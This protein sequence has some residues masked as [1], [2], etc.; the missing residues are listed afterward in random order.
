MRSGATRDE[1]K[2]GKASARRLNLNATWA[3]Y[4]DPGMYFKPTDQ[5]GMPRRQGEVLPSAFLR[6]VTCILSLC[7]LDAL[8]LVSAKG[9][10]SVQNLTGWLI[11]VASN[12][13]YQV[14]SRYKRVLRGAYAQ[15]CGA[16]ICK[17]VPKR[18]GNTCIQSCAWAQSE[19]DKRWPQLSIRETSTRREALRDQHPRVV[20]LHQERAFQ[21]SG[22]R[23]RSRP[24]FWSRNLYRALSATRLVSVKDAVKKQAKRAVMS[25]PLA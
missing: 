25:S 1:R 15:K 13:F 19:I 17:K 23:A 9:A 18:V 5:N 11:V 10:R 8:C 6:D 20:R 22:S 21:K 24:K 16:A 7:T 12:S 14:K 4:A 2:P 3:R